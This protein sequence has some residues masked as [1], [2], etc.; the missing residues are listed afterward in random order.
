MSASTHIHRKMQGDEGN[1]AKKA[2][3]QNR[4]QTHIVLPWPKQRAKEI[5]KRS[6]PA[7][8]SSSSSPSNPRNQQPCSVWPLLIPPHIQI[9]TRKISVS[10]RKQR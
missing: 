10:K 2:N 6:N 1:E 8:S 4:T 7:L 5:I 9:Q 3:E